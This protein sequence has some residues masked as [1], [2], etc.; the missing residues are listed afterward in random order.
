VEISSNPVDIC[1]TKKGELVHQ[2]PQATARTSQV[3]PCIGHYKAPVLCLSQKPD[4]Q[5]Y[6]PTENKIADGPAA[7]R[8]DISAEDKGNSI[9]KA[10]NKQDR[11]D[12][13]V[14]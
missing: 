1:R 13:R 9:A 8:R 3:I 10:A 11:S 2:A 5:I 7:V 6:Q 4:E 14:Q 12:R